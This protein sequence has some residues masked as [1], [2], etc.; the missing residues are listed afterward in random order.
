MT[1]Q[2]AQKV[3]EISLNLVVEWQAHSLSNS[4]SQQSNRTL[5]R[6]QVLADGSEVDAI[7]G[8]IA[9][10][11]HASI[12]REYL[13]GYGD[14][15]CSACTVGD[16]RRAST[17]S[18][19]GAAPSM[20]DILACG[21]CDTHGF[22]ITGK[23]GA[24]GVADRSRRCKGSI[25][26]FSMALALPDHYAISQQIFTRRGM[27]NDADA[28]DGQMIFKLPSRSGRY[29]MVVR[30]TCASVGVDSDSRRLV[31]SD[32]EIRA[33]RHKAILL[34]LRDQILSPS[35]A[36]TAKLLPHITGLHGA[37]VIRSLPGRVPVY[38]PLQPNFT[39]VL[40]NLCKHQSESCVLHAFDSVVAFSQSI[41]DLAATSVPYST[42]RNPST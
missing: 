25:I 40:R 30:Y 7:S 32:E 19:L 24:N 27:N 3:Y 22:L 10:Q 39:K 15:L 21:L 33:R 16:P 2:S 18:E 1:N 14:K 35:G 8:N 5:P 13:A 29:A 28:D 34:A 37:L 17:A 6:Q 31:I 41:G 42:Q 23:K 38:S 11:R 36:L 12:L 9:K 26:D 4:G 20:E